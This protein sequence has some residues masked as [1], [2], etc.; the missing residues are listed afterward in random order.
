MRGSRIAS[1]STSARVYVHLP[2]HPTPMLPSSD[3]PST[4]FVLAGGGSH[5]AC[6][7]GMLRA[8]VEADVLPDLIVGTSVGA[9]NGAAFAADPTRRGVERLASIWHGL[10]R[11][12]VYPLSVRGV[13][14]GLL[15]SAGHLVDQSGLRTLIRAAQLPP[16][17]EA[18]QVPLAMIAADVRDGREVV[19]RSGSSVDGVLASAAIPGLFPPVRID[20]RMLVDGAVANNTPIATAIALGARRVIVLPT[21]FSCS[22]PQPPRHPI[23]L[24]LHI[25]SLLLARQLASEASRLADLAEIVI[26]PPQCPMPVSSYDFG[27][28]ADLIGRAAETTRDWLARGGLDDTSIP[29]TLAPHTH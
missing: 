29:M 20:D 14:R 21:G 18:M 9:V 1:A 22:A 7:V 11:Q 24:A 10:S 19:L 4:A 28:S 16:L 3:T 15:G 13:V 25:V 23:A 6:Q 12:D 27:R 2:P 5:G 8:L 17:L 26:V